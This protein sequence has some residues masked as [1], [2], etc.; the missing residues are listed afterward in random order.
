MAIKKITDLDNTIQNP[1]KPPSGTTFEAE[2][3][4]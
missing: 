1:Y 2:M 3:K 4:N